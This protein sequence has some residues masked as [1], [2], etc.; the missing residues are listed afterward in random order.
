MNAMQGTISTRSLICCLGSDRK[1]AG[2]NYSCDR[3]RAITVHVIPFKTLPEPNL[4]RH[5]GKSKRVTI[6]M[7]AM[8]QYFPVVLF[9]MLHK[10]VLYG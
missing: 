4:A 9:V 8:E 2:Y 7:N 5:A 10:T 1:T 6:Q 3:K